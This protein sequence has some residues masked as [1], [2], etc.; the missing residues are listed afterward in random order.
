MF[1]SV[2]FV[3]IALFAASPAGAMAQNAFP[4]TIE[5]ALG[6]VT[7]TAPPERIVVLSNRDADTLLALGIQPVA[8][9]SIYDFE[10]GVGPWSEDLLTTEPTVWIGRELNFEAIASA[11]P[12]LIIYATSGGDRAEYE[13]LSQIAP[14]LSPPK[15]AVPW[16]AKVDESTLAIAEILGRR[17]DGEALL[18]ELDAYL[19]ETR[20]NHPEFA[21]H[22]A[23][24]L[25]IYP[26]GIA[27]YA[28]DH[29]VNDVLY[30]IGFSP[31]AA[32]QAMAEGESMVEVSAELLPQYLGDINLIF[33]YGRTLDELVAETPTL[34]TSAQARTGGLIILE[35]L[36][37]SNASVIS[38]PYALDALLPKFGA[39]L[40]D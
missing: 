12:D 33:P 32:S 10:K 24:Y 31:I 16:G 1:R 38:I 9:R 13:R 4:I 30:S 22:S 7:V 18:A 37:F 8:I 23:N 28:D 40:S 34:G 21:G 20:A 6:T 5:Q 36:A 14:T 39:A 17:A 19:A 27:S 3:G 2:L 26:G 15:G 11:D 29:I 35:N 25:D